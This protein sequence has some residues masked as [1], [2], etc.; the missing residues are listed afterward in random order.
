MPFV[1]KFS[2]GFANQLADKHP[3]GSEILADL[4]RQALDTIKAEG[5]ETS[6]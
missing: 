3:I 1:L 2:W 5:G 6:A 4:C